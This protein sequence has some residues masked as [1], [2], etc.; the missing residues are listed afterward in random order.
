MNR[1]KLD[2]TKMLEKYKEVN[3]NI[4]QKEFLSLARGWLTDKV[5][6]YRFARFKELNE[7]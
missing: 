5:Q 7:K 6:E 1:T 4:D 2:V 3:P